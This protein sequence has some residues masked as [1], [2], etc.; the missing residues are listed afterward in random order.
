MHNAITPHRHRPPGYHC[1]NTQVLFWSSTNNYDSLGWSQ[2]DAVE[3]TVFF[4]FFFRYYN[5]W[6]I[7][8][9]IWFWT[10]MKSLIS[11][12][13]ML[14][15]NPNSIAI[16]RNRSQS[17]DLFKQCRPHKNLSTDIFLHWITQYLSYFLPNITIHEM[18]QLISSL[19]HTTENRMDGNRWVFS[20]EESSS[21]LSCL[22]IGLDIR[23]LTET[24][25]IHRSIV[26]QLK[27]WIRCANGQRSRVRRRYTHFYFS[28]SLFTG[29]SSTI[30]FLPSITN[31][32]VCKRKITR[33]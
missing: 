6:H 20:S 2:N 11:L 1:A 23:A 17:R 4:F 7:S 16:L 3:Q 31:V 8:F 22:L 14:I 19:L 21:F 5:T 10:N 12:Y 25:L 13:S 27:L 30:R 29:A 9:L 32:N 28:F 24:E 26:A 33:T 15:I 18:L